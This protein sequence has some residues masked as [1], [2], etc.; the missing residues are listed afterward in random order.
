MS[1]DPP[2]LPPVQPPW[3]SFQVWWQQVL[4]QLKGTL[5]AQQTAL[6]ALA[7]AVAAQT[8]ADAAQ[9]A[10]DTVNRNDSISTSWTA[11]GDI[12]TASDAGT[13]AT[14]TVA[15]HVRHYTDATSISVTGGSITGLAYSTTYYVYYDQP[16]RSGGVVTYNASEDANVGLANAVVGRHYCGT[17]DTPAAGGGTTS[18]GVS[19]PSGGGGI[20]PLHVGEDTP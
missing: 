6:D 17:V 19:P 1:F 2:P 3:P 13:D 8:T 9:A 15:D 4:G 11:P 20:I 5:D 18:G 12:L 7:A 14:I 10:A 16:D